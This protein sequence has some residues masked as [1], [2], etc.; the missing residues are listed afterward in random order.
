[1]A[2]KKTRVTLPGSLSDL[3]RDLQN[4]GTGSMENSRSAQNKEENNNS[5]DNADNHGSESDNQQVTNQNNDDDAVARNNAAEDQQKVDNQFDRVGEE[6]HDEDVSTPAENRA[7]SSNRPNGQEYRAGEEGNDGAQKDN[8]RANQGGNVENRPLGDAA[9]KGGRA[10][11]PGRPAK[12]NTMKE[13]HIIKDDTK[14]SWDLFLD[15]AKQYKDGGGKLATIYIDGTLKNILDRMKYVGKEKLPTS[16][17]LS[18][19]V[20]R[21][22]YDHEDEI[23]K[24]LFEEKNLF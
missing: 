20:A 24:A 12:Q 13:Y 11:S 9:S 6:R 21:F 15:L 16:A 19:I 5:Q 3:V 4:G 2:K 22:I 14:D 7:Q 1:M 17:M 8:E 23:R 10:Y 18:S